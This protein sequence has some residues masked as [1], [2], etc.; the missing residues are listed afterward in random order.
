MMRVLRRFMRPK[1]VWTISYSTTSMGAG[2]GWAGTA[3]G[4]AG[5]VLAVRAGGGGVGA[6]FV[7]E[8]R[9][10]VGGGRSG[11]EGLFK[12]IEAL[13]WPTGRSLTP[14][15][16][17]FCFS[18]VAGGG[19]S[20]L[21]MTCEDLPLVSSSSFASAFGGSAALPSFRP[22]IGPAF[23]GLAPA[24]ARRTVGRRMG[25][26]VTGVAGRESL[27]WEVELFVLAGPGV[28]DL[29]LVDREENL[30]VV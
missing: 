27:E 10:E 19:A 17:S 2:S 14:P 25:V 29:E 30:P 13:A 1:A 16:G 18:G 26:G 7:D 9:R 6:V 23:C 20:R 21:L 24:T 5:C 12:S 3:A 11:S 22:L 4:G 28:D 8:E 15:A